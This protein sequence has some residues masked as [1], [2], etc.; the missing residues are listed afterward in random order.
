[1]MEN[2]THA[3][4]I[5]EAYAP[6]GSPGRPRRLDDDPVVLEDPV[7]KEIAEKHNAT[8]AQVIIVSYYYNFHI[9]FETLSLS[10]SLS[11][12]LSLSH[13]HIYVCTCTHTHTHTHAHTHR[14]AF[15]SSF[16][17]AWW[18]FPSLLIQRGLQ[19]TSRPLRFCWMLMR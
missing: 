7:I 18:S 15:P 17:E 5:L 9:V 16:T 6:I 14:C 11:L 19:R 10:L 2:N 1:M 4:I 3:G 13:T 12:C 8:P